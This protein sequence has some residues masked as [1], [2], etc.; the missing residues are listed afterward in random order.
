MKNYLIWLICILLNVNIGYGQRKISIAVLELDAAGV[1]KAEAQVISDRLRSDLFSTNKFDVL[2]RNKMN[3]ILTE[4]G[5]QQTGCTSDECA[6]EVGK[7]IGV[8]LMIA[9]RIGKIGNLFTINSRIIDVESGKVLRTAVD[10]C[11]C[12]IEDVLT[13]SISKVA[14]ILAG[15]TQQEYQQR[16]NQLRER[17]M[18]E[19]KDQMKSPAY[20]SITGF[21][22][23]VVGHLHIGKTSNTVRGVIYTLAGATGIVLGFAWDINGDGLPP[24]LAGVGVLAVSAIDA[25]ISASNYNRELLEEGFSINLKPEVINKSISLSMAYHF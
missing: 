2:E 14:N 13:K 25:G 21:V 12:P 5:F 1:S 15:T 3:E 9:G 8:R 10:D 6:V 24:F 17:K 16:Q 4:Q 11:R 7:L 19:M 20:A 23:P 22:L 18:F